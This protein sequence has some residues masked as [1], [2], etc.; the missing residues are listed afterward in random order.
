MLGRVVLAGDEDRRWR[1]VQERDSAADGR[2]VYAVRSTGVYCRPSCPSRPARRQNVR[3][4]ADCAAA[5]RAG[6]RPCQRCRPDEAVQARAVAAIRRA[7]ERIDAAEE[8]PDLATLAGDVGY[9]PS[10]LQRLF[11]AHLGLSPKQ[12]AMARRKA[13]LRQALPDAGSVTEAIY[14]AGFG[15]S[16]RAYADQGGL[17][18]T[19]GAYRTGAAGETIRY[20]PA[21]TSLGPVLV[22][23][24]A[25]GVCMI[26]FGALDD[27]VAVLTRRFAKACIVRADDD[28]ALLVA[29]VV[30]LIDA[31]S[32]GCNLPLD[33]RG[34]V[35]QERVWK[36]LALIP[37]GETV[38]YAALAARIGQPTAARAVARA[39]ATNAIAVA[40]PCHRVVRGSGDLAGYRWGE[41]R[42]AALLAREGGQPRRRRG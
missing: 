37:A 20:A 33:I 14:A 9:S 6:Y 21:A 4:Y 40:V 36:A 34:T 2:F 42:K 5:E 19:P 41:E 11:K 1:A 35:F 31:P 30:R 12:Y 26:E 29:D 3:F 24:T 32:A 39:C 23:A 16:S 10:H 18:M 8:E 13:R 28:L 15:A 27:L 17:G 22:A 25:R 38:S 7:C